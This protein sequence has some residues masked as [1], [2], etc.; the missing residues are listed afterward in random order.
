MVKSPL[1]AENKPSVNIV[2]LEITIGLNLTP[3]TIVPV[4]FT[5]NA[6]STALLVVAL[7]HSPAAAIVLVPPTNL[8]TPTPFVTIIELTSVAVLVE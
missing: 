6:N 2:P 4:A 3:G 8:S 7:F 1:P 5:S